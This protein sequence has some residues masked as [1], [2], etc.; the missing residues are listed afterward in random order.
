MKNKIISIVCLIIFA[1]FVTRNYSLE[2][3]VPLDEE[4]KIEI[5]DSELNKKLG[6]FKGY[7]NFEHAR[8][9]QVSDTSFVLEIYYRSKGKLVKDRINI[10]E[11]R[12]KEL[13]HSVSGIIRVQAPGVV[14]NQEGRAK[15]IMGS[16]ALSLTYYGWAIPAILEADEGKSGLALYMLTAGG[17]FFVPF[18]LTAKESVT[19]ASATLYIYGGTLGIAHGCFLPQLLLGSET[20]ARL[21]IA[22]GMVGSI[23]ESVGGFQYANR[24]NMDAGTAE[25]I[26][27]GGVFGMGWGVGGAHLF[28]FFEESNER[29]AA[30]IILLGSGMGLLTGKLLSEQQTYTTGDANVLEAIGI[31]G[32]YAPLAIVDI[33]GKDNEKV[34]IGASMVGSVI[35]LGIGNRLV[36]GKDFSTGQ[37]RIIT[38]GEFAGGLFGLGCAFIV[39]SD[40]DNSELFLASSSIGAVIG[41]WATYNAFRQSAQSNK[42]ESSL[43]INIEPQGLLSFIM[44]KEKNSISKK[45]VSLLKISFKF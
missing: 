43:N 33:I 20:E 38:A 4:G 26:G 16:L 18:S 24:S 34:F 44:D 19:E 14:L 45:P 15:L 7:G 30:G 9:F 1:G 11:E 17:G 8:L 32:A 23:L 42:S 25:V 35:G 40:D 39:S 6:L 37:G 2:F 41:F 29:K 31:L 3:S 22:S 27:V 13:R 21:V 12:V 28:N 10:S 36:Q 5:I